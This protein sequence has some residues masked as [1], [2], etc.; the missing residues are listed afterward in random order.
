MQSSILVK[1]CKTFVILASFAALVA[2][3]GEAPVE[4]IIIDDAA[5][6][7]QGYHLYAEPGGL[8]G[9]THWVNVGELASIEESKQVKARGGKAIPGQWIRIK[10]HFDPRE[11]WIEFKNTRPAV[12]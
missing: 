5:S 10:T 1:A 12:Q 2:C 11:G 3:G 9:T 4:Q 6:G 7:E 8:G